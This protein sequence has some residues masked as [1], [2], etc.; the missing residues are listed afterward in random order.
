VKLISLIGTRPEIVKMSPLLPKFDERFDHMLVHSGQ[1]YSASMDAIFFE[2]LQLRTPDVTLDVGSR[3]PVEQTGTIMIRFEEVL[4]Q[5]KPDMVVVQGDTNTALAGALASA[6]HRQDGVRLAHVEAGMRSFL[7]MQ[8]EELNRKLIDQMSD[9]LFVPEERDRQNALREGIGDE[10]I[11][12]AGNTVI[13]S[14]RRARS[15]PGG[16]DILAQLDVRPGEYVLA[17]FHRQETVDVTESL[18]SVCRSLVELSRQVAVVVPLHPRAWK[19]ILAN[20][21]RF[22]GP[23]LSII[24]PVGYTEMIAL[25]DNCRFL[26]TDSGGLQEEAAVL[27]VSAIVLRERTEHTAYVDSGLHTLVGTDSRQFRVAADALI[28]H[29]ELP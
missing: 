16:A 2:Q 6:K 8:P 3:P 1:H 20:N 22:T 13:E 21:V 15:L 27:G 4:M 11:V 7:P 9:V 17:T 23:D 12:V 26:V 5:E 10:R 29:S 25:L 18:A 19:M 14:C 24:E 28:D